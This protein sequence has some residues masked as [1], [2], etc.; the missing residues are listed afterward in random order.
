MV[1]V[2]SLQGLEYRLGLRTKLRTKLGMLELLLVGSDARSGLLLRRMREVRRAIHG[3]VTW[4]GLARGVG[5]VN[6]RRS[7]T[8][9]SASDVV[10]SLGGIVASICLDSLRSTSSV[11]SSK[12]FHLG[13]LR[14]RN[15][16]NILELL[17]DDL[18]IVDVN[19]WGEVSDGHGEERETPERQDFDQPV[20]EERRYEGLHRRLTIKVGSC[21]P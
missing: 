11:L 12:I 20:R 2:Q 5:G 21:Q 10:L 14:V 16:R 15:I 1:V 4:L 7:S 3:S 13:S 17:V 9:L 18:L 6:V 8:G 19:Q